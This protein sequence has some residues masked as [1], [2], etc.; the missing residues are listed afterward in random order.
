[1]HTFITL[2]SIVD[3]M[4]PL[5]SSSWYHDFPAMMGY[6]PDGLYPDGLYP[7]MG[8]TLKDCTPDCTR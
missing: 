6:T 7:L 2:L 5:A 1:M 4:C 3:M 8:C